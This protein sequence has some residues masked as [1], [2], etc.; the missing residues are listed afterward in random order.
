MK[1]IKYDGNKK[2]T[3]N[4][5]L[6]INTALNGLVITLDSLNWN[7][8]L[9]DTI[10]GEVSNYE[11]LKI[12]LD[13]L[14]YKLLMSTDIEILE[15]LI[16]NKINWGMTG[17]DIYKS[18][19]KISPKDKILEISN[20]ESPNNSILEWNQFQSTF[21][22]FL[23]M[24]QSDKNNFIVTLGEPMEENYTVWSTNKHNFHEL[25][26]KLSSINQLIIIEKLE[27]VK[28]NFFK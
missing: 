5:V 26:D 9:M 11:S 1:K 23:M 28:A 3:K 17:E 14:F 20:C 16:E 24:S 2:F 19:N 22:E 25:L 7:Y 18:L 15:L 13:I 21:L 8:N 27:D 12:D 10:L 6:A 4:E